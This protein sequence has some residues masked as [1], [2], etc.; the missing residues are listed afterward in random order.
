MLARYVAA[1]TPELDAILEQAGVLKYF[2]DYVDQATNV[3]DV[4]RTA[5]PPENRPYPIN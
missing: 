1:R 4:S 5:R 3:P 2:A